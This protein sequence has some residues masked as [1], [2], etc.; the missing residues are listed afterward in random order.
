MYC[1][2]SDWTHSKQ[3]AFDIEG[4]DPRIFILNNKV[5]II[6]ICISPY[7]GQNRCIG[8]SLFN[9]WSPI[10]LQI[11]NMKHNSIEKNWAPFVKDNKLFFV[12]NYDPLIIIH[13][14]FNIQGICNIVYKQCNILPIDT[15]KTFLRGGSNLIKYKDNYFIGCC[16]SRIHKKCYQHYTHIILLDTSNWKI[17]Y[18][19]KAVMYN[20]II[21]DKL[22]AWNVNYSSYLKEI[23]KLYNILNDKTPNIIQDPISL[24]LNDNKYFI[25][26]NVRDCISFLYEIEFKNLL[27]LKDNDV[28]QIGYYD[29]LVKKYAD[30]VN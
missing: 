16:H 11:E 29:M 7:S 1:T 12:Y 10:F 3:Y 4:K 24:Y 17:I 18:M 25:T 28:K 22:N 9:D 5:Y 21:S 20:C 30:S 15:S 26:I 27:D 19:S 13:Y 14:D 2:R 23:D 8:I 6:F